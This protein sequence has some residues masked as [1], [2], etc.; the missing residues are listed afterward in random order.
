MPLVFIHGVAN[1][2]SESYP[3]KVANRDSF[4]R[5]TVLK[6]IIGNS[7]ATIYNP[8]WG[9]L[10]PDFPK[11][12]PIIPS[13]DPKG[14]SAF[15][16]SDQ[17]VDAAAVIV[18]DAPPA[19]EVLTTLARQ[20]FGDFVDALWLHAATN[21]AISDQDDVVSE[22][23][24]LGM[25]ASA[26]VA[27]HPQP[28]WVGDAADDD[29]LI[30]K[31]VEELKKWREVPAEKPGGGGKA[32]IFES[33]GPLKSSWKWVKKGGGR[34]KKRVVDV[35]NNLII[36]KVRPGLTLGLVRFFGDVFF[37]QTYRGTKGE[38]G[39]ITSLVIDTI[40]AARKEADAKGEPLIL[41]G[42]SMGGNI[43]YDVLTHFRP[44]LKVD[45][46]VTVG[47]QASV[48]KQ[49]ELFKGQEEGG[50]LPEGSAR[51]NLRSRP[52]LAAGSTCSTHRIF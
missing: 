12:N 30:E 37:Y 20:S 23:V 4:F 17:L 28:G 36:K 11:D 51:R 24:E 9:K 8:M 48:F 21:P 16:G 14:V 19:N 27:E 26:Y 49:L 46:M 13:V 6:K 33:F 39:E 25:I 44:D 2:E 3:E 43:A 31:F 18:G 22:I 35:P 29:E 38:P 5:Q 45:A 34:L 7:K 47:C 32:E 10:I 41:V 52:E 40:E 1:R 15:G 50:T 42:H